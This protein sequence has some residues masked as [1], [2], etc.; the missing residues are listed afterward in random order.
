MIKEDY[1][2]YQKEYRDRKV[3]MLSVQLNKQKDSDIIE[4]VGTENKSATAKRL[5]RI[6]M[7]K[8]KR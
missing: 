3:V 2:K 7:G 1:N 4:A 5:I 8:I 6:G